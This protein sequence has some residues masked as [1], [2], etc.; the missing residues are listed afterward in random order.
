MTR[1]RPPANQD[2]STPRDPWLPV[3]PLVHLPLARQISGW[4]AQRDGKRSLT[5]LFEVHN[6][7]RIGRAARAVPTQRDAC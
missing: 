6:D 3:G 4:L 7:A 2:W 5:K 1:E